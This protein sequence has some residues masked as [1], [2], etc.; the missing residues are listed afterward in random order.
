MRI[1]PSILSADFANLEAELE[2]IASADLIHVDVMDG[3]FVPNLTIGL[4]VV[5]RLQQVSKV[6]LDVHLMIENPELWAGK[7]ASTGA[8][9]I[10]FHLEAS[11]DPI[12]C[13]ASIRE[14][15]ARV[16]ISISPGTPFSEVKDFM[17]LVDMLLVMTVEPGFGGQG[18]IESV[19]PKI[20]EAKDFIS[21]Q[22]LSTSLQ[23]DGG[24]GTQNIAM[25]AAAGADTFVAGSAVFSASDRNS[26]IAELR[27][28]AESI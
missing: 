23:V 9:S 10:T 22:G 11:M 20:R 24:V 18:L 15:G 5:A 19:V 16:G 17:D 26:R 6:P 1:A 2:S 25:L 14:C 28:L 4:P 7:Y 8:S 27:A 13:A 21:S 12:D 3:H